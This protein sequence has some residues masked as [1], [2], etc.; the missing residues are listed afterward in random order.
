[1]S[2]TSLGVGGVAMDTRRRNWPPEL[3][4]LLALI[5]LVA[6]FEILGRLVLGDSFLFNT[7]DLQR[8]AAVD[9]NPSSF[10]RRYH[11]DRRHAGDH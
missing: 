9:H 8:S 10:D 5:V 11:R 2:N 4:V 3:N 6:G 1:M 7:R